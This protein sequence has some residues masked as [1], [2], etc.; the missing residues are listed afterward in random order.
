[1]N[2]WV[3]EWLGCAVSIRLSVLLCTYV[4]DQSDTLR[5]DK[6]DHCRLLREQNEVHQFVD[7]QLARANTRKVSD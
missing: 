1:M 6:P 5:S 7:K 3:G 4:S 2:G